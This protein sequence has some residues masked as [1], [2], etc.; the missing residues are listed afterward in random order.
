MR[1]YKQRFLNKWRSFLV[2]KEKGMLD[3]VR[4]KALVALGL[5]HRKGMTTLVGLLL[6]SKA[7]SLVEN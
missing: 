6:P 1:Q 4:K 2:V 5:Q 7:S 3:F